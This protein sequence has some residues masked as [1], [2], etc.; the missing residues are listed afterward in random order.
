MLELVGPVLPS[1]TKSESLNLRDFLTGLGLAVVARIVEQLGG[2]LRVD[3][4][5]G[6]GSQFSFLIPL[7]LS[8]EVDRSA[9]SS[10][11]SGSSRPA[12]PS[13]PGSR[14]RSLFTGTSEHEI[15][16]LVQ[17]LSSNHMTSSRE[18]LRDTTNESKSI[19]LPSQPPATRQPSAGRFD[20]TD[21]SIP[22][23]P[24]KVDEFDRPMVS[25]PMPSPR[26][27]KLFA[28]GYFTN[29]PMS[30]SSLSAAG[31]TISTSY[32]STTFTSSKSLAE[33]IESGKLRVLIVEDNDINRTILAKRLTLNGHLVV[34]TTNGQEGLDKVTVDRSFDLVLMDIQYVCS[35]HWHPHLISQS[36]Q[37][38]DFERLRG[39]PRN[40]RTREGAACTQ[41]AFISKFKWPDTNFRSVGFPFGTTA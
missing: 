9:G 29:I 26:S 36:P 32:S 39:Y 24:V 27:E 5:V 1:L 40:P 21:S 15:E 4:K 14:P 22:I 33:P 19:E 6:E 16:N 13:K 3:S 37:D 20:V 35:L 10:R 2:Q 12:Q 7:S 8:V 11:S 23:R 41:Q 18:S 38:A 25:P 31:S 30:P 34:N 17:A 28:G